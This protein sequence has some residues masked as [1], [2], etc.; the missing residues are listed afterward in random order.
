MKKNSIVVFV[1]FWCRFEI[2]FWA[3]L[4]QKIKIVT[5]SWNFL[6]RL[7]WS[8]A[9]HF[10]CFNWKYPFEQILSLKLKFGTRNLKYAEL[11]SWSLFS[12][13]DQILFLSKFGS[14]NQNCQ[15]KLKFGTLTNSNMQI[16]V[17]MFNF[18]FFDRK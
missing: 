8:G 5:L 4:A 3:N 7:I 10:F 13:F 11:I 2:P 9:V 17:V 1:F 16:S 18:L 6:P 14:R 12:N 15:F